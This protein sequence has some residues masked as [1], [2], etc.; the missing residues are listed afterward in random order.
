MPVFAVAFNM[1]LLS[2]TLYFGSLKDQFDPGM[3]VRIKNINF[4]FRESWVL[5]M[6]LPSCMV[7]CESANF[8]ALQF[9]HL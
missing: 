4:K 7:L 2:H 1:Q 8:S 5:S 3:H 9:L 6:F